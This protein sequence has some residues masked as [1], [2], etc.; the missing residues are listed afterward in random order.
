[1]SAESCSPKKTG[2]K[3]L[4]KVKSTKKEKAREKYKDDEEP[5]TPET[6]HQE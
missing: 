3:T 6:N 2:M 1:M 5:H 4:G